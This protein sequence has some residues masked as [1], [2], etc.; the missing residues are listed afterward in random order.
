M[1]TAQDYVFTGPWFGT[2]LTDGL[3]PLHVPLDTWKGLILETDSDHD[4]ARRY[5]MRFYNFRAHIS[6]HDIKDRPHWQELLMIQEKDLPL[7]DWPKD[8]LPAPRNSAENESRF[9]AHSS[10]EWFQKIKVRLLTRR[11]VRQLTSKKDHEALVEP[12][13]A[14]DHPIENVVL[15]D[16]SWVC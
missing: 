4:R 5:I 6:S 7:Y 13:A 14:D 3:T 15:A 1:R 11:I 12:M 10:I 16:S 8:Y 9:P 2:S